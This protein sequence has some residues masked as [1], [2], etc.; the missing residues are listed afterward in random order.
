ML[1]NSKKSDEIRDVITKAESHNQHKYNYII[2]E[3]TS[4]SS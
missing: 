3:I 4:N 2:A 1:Y